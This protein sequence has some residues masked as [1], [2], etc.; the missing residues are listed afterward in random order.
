M[1]VAVVVRVSVVAV[2]VVVALVVE[3]ALHVIIFICN[4]I[5]VLYSVHCRALIPSRL[6]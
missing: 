1:A 5:A 2:V 4:L 3:E 6:F